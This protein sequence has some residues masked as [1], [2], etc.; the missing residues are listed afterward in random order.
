[1]FLSQEA[2]LWYKNAFF[3]LVFLRKHVGFEILACKQC[4]LFVLQN[5]C[6]KSYVI[7]IDIMA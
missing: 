7:K 6:H 2:E 5:N 3:E 4:H 1:M